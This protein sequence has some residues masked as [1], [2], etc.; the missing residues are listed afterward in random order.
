[1][2][3]SKRTHR[4]PAAVVRLRASTG[5]RLP[6]A[7]RRRTRRAFWWTEL[8]AEELLDVRL[9][10]LGLQLEGSSLEGR[11]EQLHAELAQA[12]LRFRPY[13]WLSTD[14]FTPDGCPGFAVPFYLAHP[15][16][17]RL[18]R[19][20]MGEA[21]GADHA[22]GMKLLRHEAGHALDNAYG[23][24]RVRAWKEHFGRFG[25]PYRDTYVPRAAS[26]AFVQHLDEWY[27]Q[28]HPCED[29]AE[30]F[31]VWLAPGGRW[32]RRYTGWKALEKLEFVEGLMERIAD[33]PSHLRT[34]A[35]EEPIRS[36]RRTLR[37]HYAQ[38]R[39][40]YAAAP[41]GPEDAPLL[42]LF[43]RLGAHGSPAASFLTRSRAELCRRVATMTGEEPYLVR[44]AFRELVARCRELGLRLSRPEDESLVDAAVILT[45]TTLRYLSG[46]IPTLRR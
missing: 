32:R 27:A 24:H 30:T 23:L 9:C 40:L 31:A 14:W 42:R 1:M 45:A 5:A 25:T 7:S 41:E 22:T 2:A 35:R 38:K 39:R 34:R 19:A 36:V 17:T 4:H 11:V 29:F 10:D 8:P 15:R 21:E 33:H 37:E 13:V 6:E 28:S 3:P 43:P 20:Q 26:R 44:Q 46:G 18:E 12:G 16:L